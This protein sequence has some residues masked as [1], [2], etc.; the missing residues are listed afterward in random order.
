MR[1]QY[2]D[3]ICR[4]ESVLLNI[5]IRGTGSLPPMF[6]VQSG[7]CV[8]RLHLIFEKKRVNW[9]TFIAASQTCVKR[10]KKRYFAGKRM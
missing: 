4:C 7:L 6:V 9:T 8:N 1:K 2:I 10:T 5:S 3:E